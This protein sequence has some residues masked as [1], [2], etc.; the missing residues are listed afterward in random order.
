[1][2]VSERD[3]LIDEVSAGNLMQLATVDQDGDPALCHVWYHA[4]FSPDRLYFISRRDRHHC[5]NIRRNSVVAGGVVSSVPS[6]LG[7][8]VCGVTFKGN[9]AE[10]PAVGFDE[11]V[12]SFLTR[13]PRASNAITVERLER[14]DTP[15]RLYE[16]VITEWVLFDEGHFPEEPRRIV[17]ALNYKSI[18]RFR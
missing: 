13:W 18:S 14:G 8:T 11:L 15:S 12:N 17:P 5:A 4:R 16:I 7:E 3:L 6:G 1:M 2:T 10:V 9:A